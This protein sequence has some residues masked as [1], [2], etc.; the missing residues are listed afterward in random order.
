[1]IRGIGDFVKTFLIILA[2]LIAFLWPIIKIVLLCMAVYIL[3]IIMW[4]IL[5]GIWG[6]LRRGGGGRRYRVPPR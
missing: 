2:L 6:Q 3:G 5:K 1:M 4:C